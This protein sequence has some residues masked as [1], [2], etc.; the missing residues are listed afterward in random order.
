MFP[1]TG[2]VWQR[3]L[4]PALATVSSVLRFWLRA[5]IRS[6]EP[7]HQLAHATS[8]NFAYLLTPLFPS[9]LGTHV[10]ALQ[11]EQGDVTAR[12]V[13]SQQQLVAA[14]VLL[15][16]AAAAAGAEGSPQQ[17]SLQQVGSLCVAAHRDC[18]VCSQT[19]HTCFGP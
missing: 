11:Q 12:I 15:Q 13:Q 5:G 8:L 2:C 19:P 7:I 6:L 9:Q 10:H 14:R 3:T 16:E 1:H 4:T 18:G 17:H